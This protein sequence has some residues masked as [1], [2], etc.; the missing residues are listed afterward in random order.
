MSINWMSRAFA[1]R[2][3]LI[4]R[5]RDLHQH[6]ELA[7]EEFRTSGIVA[8]ELSALGLEV[9][10]GVGKTGVVGILEGKRDGPTVMFRCDMDA[11]PVTE[12]N[13]VDY[14][15]QVSGKMHACG[16]DGHTAIGL[17]VA[18]LLAAERDNLA[19]KIKFVFQPAE[20]IGRGAEAMISDGVLGDPAPEVC[21]GLHL[22]N[23]LPVG[24]IG[25]LEGPLM[26]GA[27]Q[28]E[29][30]I[31][32]IGG[33]AASPENTHDPIIAGIQIGSALQTVVSRNVSGLDTAVLSITMF[34]A[35]DAKNVIPPEA[36]LAG[37]IRTYSPET[38]ALLSRRMDQIASGIAAAMQ[39][40][41]ELTMRQTSRPVINE[42]EVVTHLREVFEQIDSPRPL[43][44]TRHVR[45]MIAEDV[46]YFLEKVPGTFIFIGAANELRGLNYPHHHPRFDFDEEA[47][48]IATGFIAQAL[49]SYML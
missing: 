46:A 23:Y 34:H 8:K 26:A 48:P 9:I 6:P 30:V 24:E 14:V 33:H 36:R 49:A 17:G 19:G 25:L 39:C 31:R 27:S 38:E 28:W 43:T 10:S 2:D 35:G 29:M 44:I 4:A 37:T 7:F 3:D 16:H 20:E 47:L 13:Q 11:L 12:A 45:T 1:M 18:R 42:P 32:G 5:R 15:S 22:W 21:L 41:A 40:E